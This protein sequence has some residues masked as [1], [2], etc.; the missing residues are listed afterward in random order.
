MLRR[1]TK[2]AR[3]GAMTDTFIGKGTR[4]EGTVVAEG[5]LRVEGEI[6]GEV[7][8]EGDVFIAETGEVQASIHA[9]NLTVSGRLTGTVSVTERLELLQTGK[10]VGD[11]TMRTLIVEQ[12]GVLE[13]NCQ[14]R[15]EEEASPGK[16][17]KAARL[18][19]AG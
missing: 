4:I 14:M 3:G 10:I 6:V 11:A 8:S 5:A 16:P 15:T 9:R 19:P 7:R 13:G 2:E 1:R 12:G 18:D 17:I